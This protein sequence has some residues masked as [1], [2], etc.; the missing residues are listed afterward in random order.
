MN[1]IEN[2]ANQVARELHQF[3]KTIK[4]EYREDFFHSMNQDSWVRRFTEWLAEK[5]RC[6]AQ[7]R[8]SND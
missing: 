3:A 6:S 5:Q 2:A 4:E 7:V 8:A 1:N